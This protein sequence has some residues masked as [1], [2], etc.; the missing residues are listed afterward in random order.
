[1]YFRALIHTIIAVAALRVEE[2][3][4]SI[5]SIFPNKKINHKFKI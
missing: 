3:I 1:V 2:K 5:T 4:P